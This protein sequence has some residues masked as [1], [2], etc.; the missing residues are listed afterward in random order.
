MNTTKLVGSTLYELHST[1]KKFNLI[2]N[3]L[4]S[5]LSDSIRCYAPY[6]KSLD[7]K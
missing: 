3:N 2:F 7:K 6:L 1:S 4:S 5:H